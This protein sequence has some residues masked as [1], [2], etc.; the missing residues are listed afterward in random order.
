MRK[1]TVFIFSFIIASILNVSV[2]Y[3]EARSE[4]GEPLQVYITDKGFKIVSFSENWSTEDKL[5]EVYYE[6]LN[7]FHSKE[8]NTLEGIYLYPDSPEGTSGY[9]YE[10]SVTSKDGK[11]QYGNDA[12]I[13]VFNTDY[14]TDI[15]QMA[16]VLS[17]EYGHHFTFYYLINVENKYYSEWD[18]TGYA[19]IRNLA[20]YPKVDYGEM[21]KVD[22]SHKWDITEIAAEDYIQLFGSKLAKSSVDYLDVSERLD[23]NVSE[24]Y[25]STNSYNLYPQENLELPLA[26]EVEGLYEYWIEIA[27]FTS[28]SPSISKKPVPKITEVKSVYFKENKRYKL[29]WDEIPDDNEYEYT[30]VMYPTGIPFLPTPI[31]TVYTGENMEAYIGSDVRLDIEN[32]IGILEKFDG[33]YEIRIFVK[34]RAGFMFSSET[35]YYDFT[36]EISRYEFFYETPFKDE[37]KYIQYADNISTAVN[38]IEFTNKSEFFIPEERILDKAD[39]KIDIN[40][41]KLNLEENGSADFENIYKNLTDLFLKEV[42]RFITK[43]KNVNI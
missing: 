36:N 35:L 18:K 20:D 32:P 14:Y 2:I 4:Y 10:A 15:S 41:S 34:D 29:V 24:Y 8:I 33:E 22:Y 16:W 43:I 28:V 42:Y 3:A 5:E 27:G 21:G 11:L 9:Y 19:Q 12:Y 40:N 30:V 23:M 6:L 39:A 7:N 38:P 13:E 25:Y 31:K 17:H 26:S 1:Y 37:D